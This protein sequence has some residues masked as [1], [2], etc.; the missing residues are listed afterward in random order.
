RI[1]IPKPGGGRFFQHFRYDVHR[2]YSKNQL[3]SLLGDDWQIE[4]VY[5]G[6]LLLYPACYGVENLIDAFSKKRSYWMN[7]KTL[8]TVRAW[9]FAFRCRKLSYNIALKCKKLK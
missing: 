6:G 7:L 3:T 8:R 9:D 2:H 4:E 5:Y 1:S